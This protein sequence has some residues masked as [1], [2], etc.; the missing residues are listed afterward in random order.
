MSTSPPLSPDMSVTSVL[1]TLQTRQ[2]YDFLRIA[3]NTEFQKFLKSEQK[4][5]KNNSTESEHVV[6]SDSVIKIN[7]KQ[8]KQE[9]HL[10]IT[11]LSIY[12]FKPSSYS[13][14]KRKI[15]LS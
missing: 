12:N 5:N 2:I 3:S 7:R 11:N 8:K 1:A 10:I 13:K 6:F 14:C 9:R 4:N 15:F